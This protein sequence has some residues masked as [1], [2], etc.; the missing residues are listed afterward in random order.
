MGWFDD[1]KNWIGDKIH[2]GAAIV[3]KATEFGG[4][5]ARKVGEFAPL[6]GK[7]VGLIGSAIGAATG[8]PEITAGALAA[9]GLLNR[10]GEWGHQA[11]DVSGEVNNIAGKVG[12][13]GADLLGG[14]GGGPLT[15]GANALTSDRRRRT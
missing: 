1:V 4:H 14:G 3:K 7:G 8:S 10:I 9:S 2:K 5:V 15:M 11:S 13:F 6:V 12:D